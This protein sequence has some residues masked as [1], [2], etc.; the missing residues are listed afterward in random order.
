MYNMDI[1]YTE[2]GYDMD[3]NLKIIKKD[4]SAINE[5]KSLWQELNKIHIEKSVNF[6]SKYENFEFDERF[7]PLLKD[8]QDT[9]FNLDV[10]YNIDEK[11]NIGYCLS[12][13]TKDCG[14]I[15]SL[16]LLKEYRKMGLGDKLFN[17]ALAF[18]REHNVNNINIKVVYNNDAALH[19]Y[20]KHGFV[21]STYTLSKA[22]H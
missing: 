7:A 18:F 17:C 5:L 2:G 14:E 15:Q 4:I 19:F 13:I 12:S 11:V 1:F 10:V 21:I 6:K 16:F 3:N 22:A 9:I 8:N 20:K